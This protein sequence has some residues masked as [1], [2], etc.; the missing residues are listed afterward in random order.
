[1]KDRGWEWTYS[2]GGHHLIALMNIK[3]T[4]DFDTIGER[5]NSIW[6]RLKSISIFVSLEIFLIPG[7]YISLHELF[8]SWGKNLSNGRP[9]NDGIHHRISCWLRLHLTRSSSRQCTSC[10]H[11]YFL[12]YKNMRV[13]FLDWWWRRMA[14]T[15]H[16]QIGWILVRILWVIELSSLWCGIDRYWYRTCIVKIFSLFGNSL[17]LM[18]ICWAFRNIRNDSQK[19]HLRPNHLS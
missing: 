2:D 8:Y 6:W 10:Y 4:L 13:T 1:M 18:Y 5:D 12:G 9:A 16:M 11:E 14:Q 17:S 7:K 3:V 15:L 19:S